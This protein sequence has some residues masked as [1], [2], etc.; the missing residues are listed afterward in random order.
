MATSYFIQSVKTGQ[1]ISGYS[2]VPDQP[3]VTVTIP[4]GAAG[5]LIVSKPVILSLGGPTT[6]QAT[7]G[8]LFANPGYKDPLHLVWS[9]NRYL[10]RVVKIPEGYQIIPADGQ[11]M[12]WTTD[13]S[14]N[15]L[16]DR[17]PLF[18]R[19]LQGRS[20]TDSKESYFSIFP[21]GGGSGTVGNIQ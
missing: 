10:W 20:I 8:N 15:A 4:S 18:I 5:N 2:S 12:Y 17:L 1:Y 13:R 7:D 9:Q 11:D 14:S 3:V 16:S 19:L 6:I 21:P